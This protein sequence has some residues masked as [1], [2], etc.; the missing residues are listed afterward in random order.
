MSNTTAEEA[1]ETSI[2]SFTAAFI[3]NLVIGLIG[4]IA[5]SLI[6]RRFKY[7]Y[8]SN[9]IIQTTKLLSELSETQVQIW[10][11]LKLSNS[12]F[13]WLTPCFKLSDEEVFYLVGLDVFVYLRFVRLCLKFFVVIL[14]YGLLVLLPLNIYGTANLK[15]MSSLSMGNIELKS[16]IYW[17]HLVGAWAY[18]IIIFFM[19]YREWQTFTHYRQLY[20][21]KG[22]E[23]Q[24]SILVTDLPAYVSNTFRKRLT[25]ISGARLP[26]PSLPG[27]IL[28]SPWKNY[29]PYKHVNNIFIS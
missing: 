29:D 27:K 16:D 19:M 21:R 25:N 18:S 14:P 9:F 8:L 2:N 20:L 10:N 7:V 24:Y 22:Y 15:G 5:F 12:I 28:G 23:E 1:K 4:F 26:S 13:S 3:L 11:R 17:A 6:R